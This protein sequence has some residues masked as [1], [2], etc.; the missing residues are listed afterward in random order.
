MILAGFAGFTA[1]LVVA[2]VVRVR[3]LDERQHWVQVRDAQARALREERMRHA[4]EMLRLRRFIA[5]LTP[6]KIP[7]KGHR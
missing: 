7:E 4:G 6:E 5:V 3:W 2:I 1:G